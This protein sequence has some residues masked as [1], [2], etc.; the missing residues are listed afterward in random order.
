MILQCDQCN[1]KFRLDDAKLKPGGVKVRC[2]KCKHVFLAGAEPRQEESDFDALLSGLGAPAPAKPEEPA[3]AGE[4]AFEPQ[5][6]PSAEPPQVAA[7]MEPVV[8][9][10]PAAASRQAASEAAPTPAEAEADF[11]G[12]DFSEEALPSHA[13]PAPAAMESSDFDFNFAPE[14]PVAPS[15]AAAPPAPELGYGEFEFSEEPAPLKEDAPAPAGSALDFGEFSFSDE[16]PPQTEPAAAAPGGGLAFGEFDFNPEPGAKPQAP[17]GGPELDFGD[18][19]FAEEPVVRG[20]EPLTKKEEFDFSD[21]TFDEEPPPIREEPVAASPLDLGAHKEEAPAAPSL[22]LG[23]VQEEAAGGPPLDFGGFSFAEEAE[24]KL[25]GAAP[26]EP[27]THG[28]FAFG[29]EAGKEE[30]PAAHA[31][32]FAALAGVAGLAELAKPHAAVH[33]H[34][35]PVGAEAAEAAAAVPPAG[36]VAA[37]EVAAPAE[38]KKEAVSETPLHFDFGSL[39]AAHEGDENE[40]LPP[41]SI[42]SRRKGRSLFTVIFVTIAALLILA[43]TGAGLY[44]L[45]SGPAAL[46]RFDKLGMGFV[47][48]WFGMEAPE[49]GRIVIKNPLAAFYQNK[50]AGELF[51]VT[52]EAVNSYRKARASIHVKVSV[53]GKNGVVLTQKT[54]Y[55]GNRLS[56]EQLETLPMAKI[57]AIMNNGFGDSLSNLGVKPG[58]AISF[59][60]AIPN[61]PKDAVD[62]GVEP[63]GSTVAGQ[64]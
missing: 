53:F 50:E 48:K 13:E 57:D 19:N 64:P 60:V 2:S 47:P 42:S 38:H 49:E 31:E 12:F 35:E 28:D 22:E 14:E 36:E 61:V 40:E 4:G 6:P 18:F 23:T 62:F 27:L 17:G 46:E 34:G 26:K 25:K 32:T 30:T 16:P 3:A 59:V 10:A 56:K 7:T 11:A 33:A 37:G 54:A 45:Q 43:L 44:L 1:T 58:Q 20:E 9:E 41:L 39:S 5:P 55:C 21:F 52:G 51:V 15:V 24:E 63:V 29:E 8:P